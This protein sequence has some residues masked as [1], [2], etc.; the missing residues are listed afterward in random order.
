LFGI[1]VPGQYGLQSGF[2]QLDE[3]PKANDGTFDVRWIHGGVSIFF[4]AQEILVDH[5]SYPTDRI[6]HNSHFVPTARTRLLELGSL[7]M[8]SGV[9]LTIRPEA[10]MFVRSDYGIVA[11]CSKPDQC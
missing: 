9:S 11:R 10:R 8:T 7:A 2:D 4:I 5:A 3:V 1:H 6:A